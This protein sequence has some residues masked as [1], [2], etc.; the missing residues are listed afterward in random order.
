MSRLTSDTSQQIRLLCLGYLLPPLRDVRCGA[1]R[2]GEYDGMPVT[3]SRDDAY[4]WQSQRVLGA[5]ERAV[6]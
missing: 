6:P 1:L 4:D 2:R 5:P 3:H